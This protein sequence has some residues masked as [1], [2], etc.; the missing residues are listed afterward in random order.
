MTEEEK[1]EKNRECC[2]R[3]AMKHDR[4]EYYHRYYLENRERVLERNKKWN[5]EHR[6]EVE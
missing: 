4:T 3:W 5:R 6:N 1:K 2:K